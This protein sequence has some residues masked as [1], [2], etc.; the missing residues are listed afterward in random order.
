MWTDDRTT[1]NE[2]SV[3]AFDN[4]QAFGASSRAAKLNCGNDIKD[5]SK[6]RCSDDI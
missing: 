1:G 6:T 3:I 4:L 2:H 5:L